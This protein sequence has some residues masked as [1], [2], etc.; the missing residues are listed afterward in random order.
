MAASLRDRGHAN[1]AVWV[2]RDNLGA[3]RFYEALGGEATGV[4]GV[5][6]IEGLEIP[7][8]AYGWRDLAGLAAHQ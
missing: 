1:A 3:R 2:L 6:S 8:I 7:D 5:W 4:E